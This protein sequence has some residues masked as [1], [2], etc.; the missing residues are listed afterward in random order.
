MNDHPTERASSSSRPRGRL[1]WRVFALVLAATVAWTGSAAAEGARKRPCY[2]P[3]R[4]D[5]PGCPI[6]WSSGGGKSGSKGSATAPGPTRPSDPASPTTA[7]D[8][9]EPKAG[10]PEAGKG[11]PDRGHGDAATIGGAPTASPGGPTVQTDP[12]AASTAAG[13]GGAGV[14]AGAATAEDG[15]KWRLSGPSLGTEWSTVDEPGRKRGKTSA[16]IAATLASIGLSKETVGKTTFTSVAGGTVTAETD[17]STSSVEVSLLKGILGTSGRFADAKSGPL[18]QIGRILSGDP[19]KVERSVDLIAVEA[20]KRY[21]AETYRYKNGP[22]EARASLGDVGASGHVAAGLDEKGRPRVGLGGEAHAVAAAV[23]A[24]YTRPMRIG[25]VDVKAKLKVAAKALDGE[26][27]GALEVSSK[28][29]EA[30]VSGHVDLVSVSARPTM[31]VFGYEVGFEAMV[32]L[33]AAFKASVGFGKGSKTKTDADVDFG[34]RKGFDFVLQPAEV[35]E[36]EKS[37]RAE[38]GGGVLP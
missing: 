23:E 33:G 38:T 1:A 12:R 24:T 5:D 15:G 4:L 29:A 30:S 37:K 16:E 18:T 31:E 14:G 35:D 3:E 10:H 34:V 13:Q 11:D 36:P 25:D 19:D 28:K 8:Q 27:K 2:I 17:V 26:V 7:R 20:E 21:V 22:I 9:T 32:G 6:N